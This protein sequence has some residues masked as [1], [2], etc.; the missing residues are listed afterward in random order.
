MSMAYLRGGACSI[1][2]CLSRTLG[3]EPRYHVMPSV[4]SGAEH[5][6]SSDCHNIDGEEPVMSCACWGSV[7]VFAPPLHLLPIH[8]T[9]EMSFQ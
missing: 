2:L 7:I 3:V 1:I 8:V 9:P 6:A 4:H 5:A